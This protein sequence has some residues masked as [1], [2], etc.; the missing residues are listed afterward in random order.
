[1]AAVPPSKQPV[2][3]IG[4]AEANALLNLGR[5]TMIDV[6]SVE[7]YAGGHIPGAFNVPL[8]H[9]RARLAQFPRDQILIFY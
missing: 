2:T 5:A 6:R 8:R 1:M 7:D 4:P 3:R 9:L